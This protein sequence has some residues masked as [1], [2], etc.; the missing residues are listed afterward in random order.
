MTYSVE[1]LGEGHDLEP[2]DSGNDELTDWLRHHARHATAQ[3]SRTYLLVEDKTRR[4]V[5]YFSLAPHIMERADAPKRVGR[6]GPRQIPAIL[7]AKLALDRSEQGR[8]LGSELLIRALETAVGAAR[9][10]GGKVVVVDA[11]DEAAA[12]FYERHDFQRTPGN[13]R[14]LVQKLSTVASALDQ[15]WP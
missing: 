10:A 2:F 3:G 15:P 8:G 11:I 9:A 4:V 14:R 6:G 7:L 1:A 12:R 13:P 5:G